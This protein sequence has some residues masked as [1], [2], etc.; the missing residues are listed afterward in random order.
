MTKTPPTEFS[1]PATEARRTT[2][3]PHTLAEDTYA[4]GIAC[5]LIVFGMVLLRQ[6]GLVT[7]GIAGI[8]LL[9]S[10]II[11]IPATVLLFFVNLPFFWLAARMAG[12]EFALRSFIANL[13]IMG[14]GGLLPA[15]IHVDTV[16]PV[17]AA[18]LG[19][20]VIGL[21]ILMLARHGAGV[22]GVGVAALLL[23]RT[24]GWNVGKTQMCVDLVVLL[25]SLAVLDS[26][27]FAL[28]VFSA[29]CINGVLV[30]NHR[31]GRYM[32]Y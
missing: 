15:V 13:G 27:R 1:D 29:I 4:A 25:A 14:V 12:S 18:F 32:G 3:R 21:G 5:V 6:A 17:F 7:G 31:P 28:S 8:T 24:R 2:A 10:Y 30:V 16:N 11:G 19:G 9:L 23:Q 22:G 26:T 20:S